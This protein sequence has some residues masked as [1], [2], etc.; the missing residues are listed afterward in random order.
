[1]GSSSTDA[2]SVNARILSDCAQ[3]S[4]KSHCADQDGRYFRRRARDGTDG[5]LNAIV[6][7]DER[8]V[9]SGEFGGGL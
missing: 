5:D 9:G 2:A 3:A 8:S 6:G 7:K 1:M 4:E